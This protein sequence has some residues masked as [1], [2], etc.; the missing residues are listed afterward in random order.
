[1]RVQRLRPV[2]AAGLV[3]LFAH[4]ISMGYALGLLLILYVIT[5][6]MASNTATKAVSTEQRMNAL[7]PKVGTIEAT[8]NNALPKSGGTVTGS[9][10]VDGDHTIGGTLYGSGGTLL[11]GSNMG[12][13]GSATVDSD[14]TV[15]GNHN[16]DGNVGIG[17]A[18][19]GEGGA[20]L[21]ASAQIN[22]TAM[23]TSGG[24]TADGGFTSH[25]G[26][27]ADGNI[28]ANNYSGTY[29]GGQGNPGAYPASGSPSNAGLATYSNQI[30]EVLQNAGLV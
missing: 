29:N 10:V 4:V 22:G 27:H 9:V 17:G 26:I 5:T 19:S 16:V 30:V 25:A 28:S 24:M 15:H 11:M 1:M 6:A 14:F 3:E 18:I 2:L 8:A 21:T 20:N 13:A 7:V 23:T 12:I